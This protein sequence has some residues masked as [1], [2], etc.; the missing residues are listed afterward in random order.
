MYMD[1][2]NLTEITVSNVED[3]DIN[4]SSARE[5]TLNFIEAFNKQNPKF[6]L[7]TLAREWVYKDLS[8]SYSDE[9]EFVEE[10]LQRSTTDELYSKIPDRVSD[11]FLEVFQREI[12]ELV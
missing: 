1:W 10:L 12:N 4:R 9:S 2:T 5:I 3:T 6:D 7:S 11:Q 8:E